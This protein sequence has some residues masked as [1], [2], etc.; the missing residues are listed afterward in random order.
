MELWSFGLEREKDPSEFSVSLERRELRLRER[1][2][3]VSAMK[4]QSRN[5]GRF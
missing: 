3:G 4:V 5:F 2:V 1:G